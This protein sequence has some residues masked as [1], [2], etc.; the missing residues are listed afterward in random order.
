MKILAKNLNWVQPNFLGKTVQIDNFLKSI[1]ARKHLTTI[2]PQPTPQFEQERTDLH[3]ACC[4]LF[5]LYASL[6]IRGSVADGH[7]T[8]V[9]VSIQKDVC[10][11]LCVIYFL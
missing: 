7:T 2:P 11:S 8:C 6:H 1:A 9:I 4:I 5:G 10:S 3:S